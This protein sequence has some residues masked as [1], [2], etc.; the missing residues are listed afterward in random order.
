[1]AVLNIK[2]PEIHALAA[3]VA[4]R[5]GWSLTRAVRE[6]LR[7]RLARDTSSPARLDRK[8][9]RVM[10]LAARASSKPVMDN[11]SAEEMLG[12]DEIGVPH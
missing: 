6:A 9:A 7:D 2:D 1:M 12:Y 11:R 3:E 10:E 5:N 4:R 8:V